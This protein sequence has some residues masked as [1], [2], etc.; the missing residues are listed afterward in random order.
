MNKLKVVLLCHYWSKETEQMLGLKH[1]FRELSPW[2]QEYINLFKNN[3]DIELHVLAPNYTANKNI[4]IFEEGIHYHFYHYAPTVL[5]LL[6]V[7]IIK[8]KLKHDEPYKIAER[9]ANVLTNFYTVEKEV[10]KLIKTINPHV[11]H[12]FGTENP[13]YSAGVVSLMNQYPIVITIQGYAYLAE[14]R[15]MHLDKKFQLIRRRI[16]KKVNTNARYLIVSPSSPDMPEFKPFENGQKRLISGGNITKIPNV[17]AEQA[18]KEY[19]VSFYGR[20]TPD[21]G[22]EDLVKAIG[23]LHDKGLSLKTLIIGKCTPAYQEKLQTLAEIQNA[24]S[25]IHFTGFVEDHDDVYKYAASAKMVALPTHVDLMPNTIREALAMGLPVIASDAG[26][27][28]TLNKDRECVALHKVG[29]S[30]DLAC[31]ILKVFSDS[32][33]QQMLIANGRITFNEKFSMSRV[34]SR[35]IEIYQDVFSDYCKKLGSDENL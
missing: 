24:A 32:N 33:Y 15:R 18:Q 10:T 2:I 13:D 20:V 23:I 30:E 25:L 5:S 6:I 34:Y 8:Y 27:I 31:K 21:K 3:H 22:V 17:N 12:V 35:S 14:D 26:Y 28:P 19:D 16:E 4:S 7:P 11:I 29:D 1:Y 9:S